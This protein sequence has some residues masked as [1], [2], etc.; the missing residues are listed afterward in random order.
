[1]VPQNTTPPRRPSRLLFPYKGRCQRVLVT[2][3]VSTT[4]SAMLPDFSQTNDSVIKLEDKTIIF[5]D[6]NEI[7]F[8]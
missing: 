1:M 5:F 2:I 8:Q 7:Y 3:A 4:R 6:L